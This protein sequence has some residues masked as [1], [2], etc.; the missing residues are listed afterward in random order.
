MTEKKLRKNREGEKG[1]AMITVLLVAFLLLTASAGILLE[2]SMNTANLTDAVSEQQAYNAA[3]SGIQSTLNVLRR[4]VVP[5][6]LIDSSK[7][8]SDPANQI[9]FLKALK[10][11]T[12]NKT[13]ETG[14]QARLSRWM[15]YDATQ[16]DRV[17]L[18]GANSGYAYKITLDDPDNT[19]DLTTFSTNGT[20]N[21][22][23]SSLTLGSGS[24]TATISY[25]STSVTDLN[26]S[27]GSANTTLGKF[28]ITTTGTGS[29]LPSDVRF[30]INFTM[31]APYSGVRT[32]RGT[33][34]AGLIPAAT[35]STIQFKFDSPAYVLFGSSITLTSNII[36]PAV[37]S[38]NSV[39]VPINVSM[40]PAEPLKLLIRS[41]GFGPRG[42]QKIL[43]A[44]VQK[45]FF[46][47]LSA[48]AALTLIGSSSGFVFKPGMS[49][50][51]TYSGDD[52]ASTVNLPSIGTTNP[53]NLN[54]VINTPLKTAPFPQ[55]DDVTA[56]M[57]YWLQSTY[58]LDDTIQ[59][60]KRVA[61]SSG[62]YYASGVTPPNFG[63]YV[64]ANGITFADGD[65]SFSGAGGG[66]LVCTGKLTLNGGVDFKGLIIVTGASGLDR[67]GGGN[68]GLE[69]NTVIAPYNPANLA[70]G[71]LG[72]KYDISGGGTSEIRYDSSSVA[73]GLTAVSNFVLGVAE[74]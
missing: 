51:V 66:I 68:G 9:D 22:T 48:P 4:N 11:A 21:S 38:G 20:I 2:A 36:N 64:T 27:S 50:N 7:P 46:N 41:T 67:S 13:G 26:M 71:F 17:M 65:V 6:P 55:P 60:L 39:D 28:V 53:A 10:L 29:S 63:S 69:G 70:A 30:A 59:E 1:A 19:G 42:A 31:T 23:G 56:E 14:T 34:K 73:N 40:T 62:R 61:Q 58:N 44:I 43:E 33:I 18:G 5:N 72:P 15:S 3:E 45:N 12:S 32:V 49:N 37:P 52:V 8:A 24:N 57:P 25:V 74:K 47:G 35:A 54:T 16:S